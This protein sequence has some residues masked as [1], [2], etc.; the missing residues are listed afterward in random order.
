MAQWHS[1]GHEDMLVVGAMKRVDVAGEVLLV[2][3]VE[4]GFFATQGRCPHLRALL[5]RGRLEGEVVTCPAHGSR[6]DVRTGK[7]LD[8]VEGLPGVVRRAAQ[9]LSKPRDLVTF[10][11]RVQDGQVW[12]KV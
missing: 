8:W 10:P 11:V 3:R 4:D 5:T 1:I 6:F 9:A 2:A 12:V 7:C